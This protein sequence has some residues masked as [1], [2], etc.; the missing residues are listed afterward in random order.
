M[1]GWLTALHS[2]D[3][4]NK[5]MKEISSEIGWSRLLWLFFKGSRMYWTDFI[6]KC[7]WNSSTLLTTFQSQLKILRNT[8]T[9]LLLVTSKQLNRS[10]WGQRDTWENWQQ[11]T[12][13]VSWHI[14]CWRLR[15][16]REYASMG[17]ALL[18]QSQRRFTLFYVPFIP[19]TLLMPMVKAG[20]T[21][22]STSSCRW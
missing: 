21:L 13:Q 17:S 4:E 6:L 18:D 12:S 1:T 3:W 10:N 11:S 2:G 20:S 7:F 8:T 14:F 16:Y 15:C 9:I 19:L 22:A 5:E